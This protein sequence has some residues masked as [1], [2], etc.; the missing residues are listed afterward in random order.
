[1]GKESI[2]IA[3]GGNALED[4][5]CSPTSEN[6]LKVIKETC[7]HI[8]EIIKEGYRVTLVHGNGPQV[9]RLII[10][11]EAGKES[12]PALSL[13]VLDSMTQGY[14]GYQ[15]QQ[16]LKCELK[17]QSLKNDVVTI[18]TQVVVDKND[19][20]FTNPTKPVGPFYDEEE[21]NLL[22]A[23][24]KAIYKKDSNRGYRKV[25]PSPIPLKIVEID[26]IKKLSEDTIVIACGGGGIP[27]V[28]EGGCY[29]GVEAVIDKDFASELLA[30]ELDADTLLILTQVEHASLNYGTKEEKTIGAIKQE[31]LL[32]LVTEGHFAEGSMLPKVSS[33]LKFVE[34]GNNKRA[35]ITSL[36]KGFLAL[37]EETGTII[38]K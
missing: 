22:M 19:E 13:D 4:G 16:A 9:G 10:A 25:V 12:L 17:K 6:Q 15:I 11:Q 7:K 37:K 18:V 38:S 23:K 2:V 35:I 34:K 24:T 28:E 26:T 27:V 36:D 29:K 8:V 21:A 30:E 5:K 1:M 32:K 20:G 31:E 14:I 33:G 3:L